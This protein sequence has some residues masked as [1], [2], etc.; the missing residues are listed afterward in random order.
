VVP[1]GVETVLV[2]SWTAGAVGALVIGVE[3]VLVGG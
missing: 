1:L 3:T 2:G